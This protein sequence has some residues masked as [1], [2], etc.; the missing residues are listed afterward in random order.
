[1]FSCH[2]HLSPIASAAPV[3]SWRN[4]IK[5]IKYLLTPYTP[6]ER[7]DLALH[8]N[9]QTQGKG[10][11][12]MQST[13]PQTLGYNLADSPVGMLAWIYEKL[14]QWSDSYPW[15]DE[16]GAYM[17]LNIPC[18]T[19]TR[20]VSI[21]LGIDLLVLARG[22]C[23]IGEDLLRSEGISRPP[24]IAPLAGNGACRYIFLSKGNI[25]ITQ[26]VGLFLHGFFLVDQ[27]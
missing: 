11:H 14:V 25:S 20:W 8:S 23:S 16:E 4:P 12:L 6:R 5:Y 13:R 18:F 17:I 24:G 21:D 2:F 10:Y 1:M 27:G 26:S 22:S 7:N 19:L 3:S 9:F 15:T